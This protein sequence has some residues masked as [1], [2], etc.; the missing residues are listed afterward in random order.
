[1]NKALAPK[2]IIITRGDVTMSKYVYLAIFTKE[3]KGYSVCFPDVQGCYT[4]GE[5]LT[6][7]MDMAKDALNLCF[8]DLKRTKL[9]L[10][11]PLILIQFAQRQ[12]NL[13]P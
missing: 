3:D 10:I 4:Q 7:A 12:T 13:L 5:T 2:H 11:H 8:M 6:E 9:Q 1:M